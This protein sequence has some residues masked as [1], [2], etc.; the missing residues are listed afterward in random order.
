MRNKLI[1]PLFITALTL[2]GCVSGTAI[3]QDYI[4]SNP[5]MSDRERGA[6][7]NSRIYV[8]MPAA[9]V[10]ASWGQPY[11]VVQGTA[12]YGNSQTWYYKYFYQYWR[13]KAIVFFIQDENGV[14]RVYDITQL[15]H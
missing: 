7:E 1:I 9:S 5:D 11:E 15:A 6:V 12:A 8:G 14:Y 2:I 4:A 3:K 10:R 13:T